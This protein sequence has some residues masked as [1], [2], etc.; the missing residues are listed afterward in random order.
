MDLHGAVAEF[1]NLGYVSIGKGPKHPKGD[2]NLQQAIDEFLAEYPTIARDRSFANFL[3][4]YSAAAI[5]WPDEQLT[6]EIYGFS[7]DITLLIAQPEET[8]VD[9]QGFFRFS[10]ILVKPGPHGEKAIDGLYA[11]DVSQNRSAG[12]YQKTTVWT[13]DSD[14]INYVWYCR[15]F[16]EWLSRVVEA[17]GRLPLVTYSP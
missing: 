8:L 10:E 6:I 2:P 3:E 13:T 14:T 7:S 17:E 15:T 5:D 4:Y 11:F 16:L 12:I 9:A 1:Q